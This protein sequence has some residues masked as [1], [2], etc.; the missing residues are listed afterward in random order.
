MQGEESQVVFDGYTL[1]AFN[2]EPWGIGY[3][4]PFAAQRKTMHQFSIA[5]LY[6]VVLLEFESGM[7]AFG[8]Y[9][10]VW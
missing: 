9:C 5:V 10:V 8:R 6:I 1:P 3:P 4:W 2:T 7:T